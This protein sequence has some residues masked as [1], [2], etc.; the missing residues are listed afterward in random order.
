MTMPMG[1]SVWA[2]GGGPRPRTLAASNTRLLALGNRQTVVGGQ[3][4]PDIAS[5]DVSSE[6]T[7][8]AKPCGST[9]SRGRS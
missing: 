3:R 2:G 5:A 4:A 6:R 7:P 8:R 9:A 1:G